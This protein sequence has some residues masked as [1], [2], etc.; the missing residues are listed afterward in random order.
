MHFRYSILVRNI[1]AVTDEECGD[2][3]LEL[4]WRRRLFDGL[5]ERCLDES[6]L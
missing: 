1:S 2:L 4:L 5:R 6:V 3:C